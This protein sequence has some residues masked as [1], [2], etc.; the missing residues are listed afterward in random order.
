MA[1][2]I[3]SQLRDALAYIDGLE[4]T[5]KSLPEEPAWDG[6]GLHLL[7]PNVIPL[8]TDY[9]GDKNPVAW[10]VANDFEGYDLTTEEPR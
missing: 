6:G 10:L 1:H 8:T 3:P 2:L 7:L 9:S 4:K 5:I